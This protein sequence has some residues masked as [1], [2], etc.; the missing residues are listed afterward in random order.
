V[1]CGSGR[2]DVHLN[3]GDG[4]FAMMCSYNPACELFQDDCEDEP[5]DKIMDC[6]IA[7]A[8]EGLAVCDQRS[9]NWVDEG[10]PCFYR[11]DCGDSQICHRGPPDADPDAGI[12]GRCRY[13]CIVSDWQNLTPGLGGCPQTPGPQTCHDGGAQAFP[14]VGICVPD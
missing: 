10:G 7:D 14:D 5:P 8:E 9:S 2:C 6:H 4:K 1:P 11:N 3:V 13:L 12:A